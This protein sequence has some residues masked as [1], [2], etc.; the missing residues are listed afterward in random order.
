MG[1]RYH[2]LIVCFSGKTKVTIAMIRASQDLHVIPCI[3]FP[4]GNEKNT[5]ILIFGD[6]N[7]SQ[8]TFHCHVYIIKSAV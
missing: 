5:S 1:I 7:T 4:N 3:L 8:N 6:K 2:L